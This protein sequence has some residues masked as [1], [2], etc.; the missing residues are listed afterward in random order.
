MTILR[1]VGKDFN[2]NCL[3]DGLNLKILQ[4]TPSDSDVYPN[5]IYK[6]LQGEKEVDEFEQGRRTRS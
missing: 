2:V 3:K 1:D 4:I 6:C 5:S